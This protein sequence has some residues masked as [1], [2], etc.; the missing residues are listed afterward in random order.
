M[1]YWVISF[2]IAGLLSTL[3]SLPG[4][5]IS[6]VYLT[7]GETRVGFVSVLAD[8][9]TVRGKDRLF[10]YSDYA[11]HRIEHMTGESALVGSENVLLLEKPEK[12]GKVTIQVPKGSEVIVLDHKG[13][14]VQIEVYAGDNKKFGWIPAEDLADSV[15][16]NLVPPDTKFKKPPPD[17]L[18]RP[19]LFGVTE[20]G[21][22]RFREALR[23]GNETDFRSNPDVTGL[24]L[25][26]GPRAHQEM[27]PPSEDSLNETGFGTEGGGEDPELSAP[28][29]LEA[30]PSE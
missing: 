2:A 16:F 24:D 8:R 22:R 18:N 12:Y 23:G 4:W 20:E 21:R 19:D 5:S 15:L 1:R 14:W 26:P 3:L 25:F 6:N 29:S 7:N 27:L 13:D 28:E 11:V 30:T 10:Q 17:K 9:V